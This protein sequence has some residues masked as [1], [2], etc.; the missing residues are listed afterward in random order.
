MGK[1]TR[2]LLDGADC[3]YP[4]RPLNICIIFFSLKPV[5]AIIPG[6]TLFCCRQT[7]TEDK[8]LSDTSTEVLQQEQLV[9][10]CISLSTIWVALYAPPMRKMG[11]SE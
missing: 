7:H 9:F 1:R 6:L 10:V 3:H 11:E 5:A 4:M 2:S 8:G